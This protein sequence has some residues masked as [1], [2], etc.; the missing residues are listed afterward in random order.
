[1]PVSVEFTLSERMFTKKDLK[2]FLP[3]FSSLNNILK[4]L[5]ISLNQFYSY[6]ASHNVKS[7]KKLSIFFIIIRKT[8]LNTYPLL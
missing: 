2:N 3:I 7:Y 4:R 6:Y 5:W 1:M 8:G